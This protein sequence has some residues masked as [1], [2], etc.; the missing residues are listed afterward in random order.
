VLVDG[1]PCAKDVA[2]QKE[3]KTV[4]CQ[5]TGQLIRV[6]VSKTNHPFTI[7]EFDVI[8]AAADCVQFAHVTGTH[9]GINGD[10]HWKPSQG[11]YCRTDQKMVIRRGDGG[12]NF[13]SATGCTVTIRCLGSSGRS[14]YLGDHNGKPREAVVF[15]WGNSKDSSL[16]YKTKCKEAAPTPQPV[17]PPGQP[18]TEAASGTSVFDRIDVDDNNKI[19][20]NEWKNALDK[21]EKALDNGKKPSEAMLGIFDAV[22]TQG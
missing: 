11:F 18:A 16:A 10:Y 5:S 22:A 12:W 13:C 21:E 19:D 15:D 7:C 17:A 1:K 2:I 8:E 20:R 9:S 4:P 14:G 6:Q 3:T